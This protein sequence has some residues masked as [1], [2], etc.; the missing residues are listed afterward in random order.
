VPAT[1]PPDII[2][3]NKFKIPLPHEQADVTVASAAWGMGAAARSL[4]LQP[5]KKGISIRDGNV[6]LGAR[7]ELRALRKELTHH[8]PARAAQPKEGRRDRKPCKGDWGEVPVQ[9]P[10]RVPATPAHEPAL[11]RGADRATKPTSPRSCASA[12][13]TGNANNSHQLH[14]HLQAR[15]SAQRKPSCSLHLYTRKH[16]S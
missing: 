3:I 12:P 16:S 7:A 2:K 11:T 13:P 4:F 5:I 9:Q 8:L 6:L 14:L 1:K 10:A 15:I